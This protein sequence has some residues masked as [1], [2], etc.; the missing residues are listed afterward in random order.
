[1]PKVTGPCFSLTASKSLKKF[2]IYQR[3]KGLNIVVKYHKPGSREPYTASDSQKTQR[4]KIGNLV[5]QWQLLSSITKGVW[6]NYA[7]FIKYIGT[8][9]HYYISKG[10]LMPSLT[11]VRIFFG[12]FVAKV[13]SLGYLEVKT[14]T[15]DKCFSQEFTELKDEAVILTPTPGKKVEVIQ[16]YI[17]SKSDDDVK[18]FFADGDIKNIFVLYPTKKSSALGAIICGTGDVD[19][20]VK[21]TCGKD[22]FV[23]FGYNEV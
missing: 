14:H 4:S 13:T 17:A 22:T 16:V 1:M 23:Q 11:D 7:K 3:K 12:E 10:G 2:I 9:Y 18:L 15:P 21:L 6:D 8:G 19:E 20:P 5:A